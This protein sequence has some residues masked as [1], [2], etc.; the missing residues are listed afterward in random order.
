MALNLSGLANNGSV[1][2]GVNTQPKQSLNTG[3]LNGSSPQI[4]GLTLPNPPQQTSSSLTGNVPLGN[5]PGLIKSTPST[6]VK[7][8]TDVQGNTTTYHAP[9]SDPSVLAQQQMLNQKYGAGLVEDG[10]AGP[11][12]EAAISQYLTNSNSSSTTPQPPSTSVAPQKNADGSYT[13]TGGAV[14]NADGTVRTP[15]TSPAPLTTGG[16]APNVLQS[17][18]QTQNEAETQQQL[19]ASGQETPLEQQYIAE[20]EKA[21]GFQNTGQLGQYSDASMYAGDATPPTSLINQPDLAGRASADN[22]LYNTFANIYGS[23]AQQGLTAANTIAT[24]G[25]QA[26]QGAYSGAQNQAGRATGAAGTV[27]GAVAPLAN[28]PYALNPAT[29]TY[30][31]SGLNSGTSATD[32]VTNAGMLLGLQSGAASEASAEGN[33]AGQNATALGTAATQANAQSIGNYTNQNTTIS[34]STAKLDNIAMGNNGSGGLIA[35]MG[36]TKFNPT[37]TPVGN[38]TYSQYFTSSNPA[39]KSGILAGLGEIQNQISNV[40][41]SSTGLTPTAVSAITNSYDLTTLNPQQLNDF[42]L[43]IKSYAQSNIAA[44]QDSINRLKSGGNVNTTPTLLPAPAPNSTGTAIAGT[45]ATLGASLIEKII[46]QAGNAVAG[47][48]AGAASGLAKSVLG[49]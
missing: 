8:T 25:E 37:S 15:A 45:G 33:I 13:S 20:V 11:K 21:K 43:Y 16:Q 5:N 1:I 49:L 41:S 27:L 4:S 39:A 30:T 47:A 31:G 18:Q 17:G 42:L 6:A 22:G 36:T 38:Q 23:Q 2:G 40:I 10:I 3:L 9:K 7:S 24:R 34:N 48:T 26:A 19:Q 44:N 28:T 14:I 46:D 32:A 12:T 35:N 29:G